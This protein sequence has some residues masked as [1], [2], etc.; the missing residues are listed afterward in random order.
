M[1]NILF[2]RSTVNVAKK[3]TLPLRTFAVHTK[4]TKEHEWIKY[5]DETMEGQFGI[6]QHAANELGDIV[7]VDLPFEGDTFAPGDAIGAV[8]SVKTSAQIYTPVDVE[9]LGNN[10]EIEA[11]PELVNQSPMEDGWITKIKVTSLDNAKDLL[12]EEEYQ[13]FLKTLE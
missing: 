4:F 10:Q 12:S 7:F 5:D 3:T 2:K 6:T 8:E 13:K 1:L 11:T 9:I